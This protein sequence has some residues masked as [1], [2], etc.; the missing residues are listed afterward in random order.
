LIT[1]RAPAIRPPASSEKALQ[2]GSFA[3]VIT[4]VTIVTFLLMREKSS[5]ENAAVTAAN[6]I[7]QLIDTDVLRNARLYDQALQGMI[8]AIENPALN[9]LPNALQ[10]RLLFDRAITAPLLGDLLWIDEQGRI[11]AD[12]IVTPPRQASFTTWQSFISLKAQDQGLV[13]SKPFMDSLGGLGWCISFSR[14]ISGPGGEF[15]GMA[16]GALRLSYFD[17]LF[18]RLRI[19]QDSNVSLISDSGILLARQPESPGQPSIGRDFSQT[20]NFQRMVRENSGHFAEISALTGKTRLYTFSKV[21]DLPLIVVVAL[22]TDAV[23]ASW[24]RTAMLVSVATG[25]LCIGILWLSRLLG[26]ELRLRRG[27]E[28]SLAA[29]AATD[30]LTGLANR[31]RLDLT[32]SNEWA[33][34]QREGK[35]LA[36]L[37]ID[38]DHFKAFNERHGHA[39]GD[40]ALRDVARTIEQ[41]IRRPG[42]LAARYGGEEFL[43]VLPATDLNGALIIAETIRHGVE[44]LPPFAG[45]TRPT[46]VS[47]G[48]SAHPVVSGFTLQMLM[49]AAD[50]ALYRAKSEGRNRVGFDEPGR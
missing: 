27:A 3:A 6:N 41:S 29:L 1:S 42:D 24:W 23:Y 46:T 34:A 30:S 12:S 43:V 17:E 18:N 31:R 9:D 48:V 47:I 37:M 35:P 38:V 16:T 14:R 25:L 22:S 39:G 8:D 36:V 28:Q 50:Q 40:Q 45:D 32:L 26:R 2:W 21:G 4:I 49:S 44:A 33:R 5:A 11:V 10:R 7:V 13:I 19:G 15:R 20:P